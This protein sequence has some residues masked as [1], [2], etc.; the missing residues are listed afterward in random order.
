VCGD[1]AVF[2]GEACDDGNAVDGDGCSSACVLEAGFD[3]V[4]VEEAPP[5]QQV[6]PITYRD[7]RGRDLDGGHCDFQRS[8]APP[9]QCNDAT[10]SGNDVG[11]VRS[12]WD[13]VTKKPVYARDVDRSPST[14]SA[15]FFSQWYTDVTDVNR[16]IGDSLT[17][18]RQDDGTY[19]FEDTSFFPLNERGFVGAGLEQL[20][21]DGGGTPQN[22]HFTSELRF[23][24]TWTGDAITLT[25]F[26]DDDVFVFIN[27]VLAVD[28]G[29]VHGPIER[30]VTISGANEGAFGMQAGGVYEAAVFQAERQTSGSQY[31]LTLAGFFPPRTSCVG[32]CGDGV[33]V[34]GEACDDGAANN[35]GA[36]GGCTATCERAPF[37]G[38]G[39]ISN[40]E[41]CDDGRRNGRPGFCDA[42]CQGESATCGNG[43]L[44]PGEE[45]D[46]GTAE[47]TG[48]YGGCNVDC[49]SAPFCGDGVTQ[50]PEQCDLGANNG[51]GPCTATC[52]LNIGG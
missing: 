41:V 45:C 15:A 1:G 11:I 3:C 18:L 33:V 19:V 17:L 12:T 28:I 22:F 42:L 16:T 27:G 46:D 23:W 48:S 2:I 30:S 43:V 20:R 38:D 9:A 44:D 7:F 50:E 10:G 5:A 35:V 52:L 32:V 4:L 13:A 14:T 49:T 31:K 34:G 25:F 29:G 37:C 6:I 21:S 36:Y 51:S 47:N 40:D 8:A 26:G 39:A 24:F